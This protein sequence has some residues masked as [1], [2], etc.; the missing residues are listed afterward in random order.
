MILYGVLLL[1]I[2]GIY[3]EYIGNILGICWEYVGIIWNCQYLSQFITRN[4]INQPVWTT[5][6]FEHCSGYIGEEMKKSPSS[7]VVN[8]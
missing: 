6:G 3:W 4:P 7:E 5:E 2:L 1:N 8:E